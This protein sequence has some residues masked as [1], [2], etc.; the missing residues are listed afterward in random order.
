MSFLK[1]KS[2]YRPTRL[3]TVLAWAFTGASGLA[4]LWL[5]LRDLAVL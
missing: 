1:P 5:V 3:E 4:V 2:G